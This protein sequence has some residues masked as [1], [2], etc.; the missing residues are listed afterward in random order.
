LQ[1][2]CILVAASF[3]AWLKTQLRENKED[4]NRDK[5]S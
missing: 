1:H 5:D 2:F 4:I 3:K